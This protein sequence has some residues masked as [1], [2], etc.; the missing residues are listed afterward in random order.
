M[1]QIRPS[2]SLKPI[3]ALAVAQIVAP[4]PEGSS[5]APGDERPKRA[6][7]MPRDGDEI[8]APRGPRLT[9]HPR[10]SGLQQGPPSAAIQPVRLPTQATLISLG[11]GA[12]A[13]A[14]YAISCLGRRT[15]HARP[16]RRSVQPPPSSDL[17]RVL[18][19]AAFVAPRASGIGPGGG[20][21]RR[22]V[23]VGKQPP[24]SLLLVQLLLLSLFP[25]SP[26]YP[27]HPPA[28]SCTF[29]HPNGLCIEQSG[30]EAVSSPP[31]AANPPIGR[32]LRTPGPPR[33]IIK[34]PRAS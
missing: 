34:S 2:W 9:R 21:S 29:C 7:V 11:P 28:I 32:S 1:S 33:M 22:P 16:S 24:P 3:V 19:R 17:S 18:C 5:T 8:P 10:G 26:V 6:V 31:L 13:G 12:L 27:R 4:G 30:I 14:T 25:V 23:D 20:V 15:A